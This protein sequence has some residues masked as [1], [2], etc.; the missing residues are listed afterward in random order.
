MKCPKC[1]SDNPEDT[2]FCGNCAS[3]LYPS[4]NV[5]IS[6]TK[7][8]QT[9]VKDFIKGTTF[10]GRYQLR[11]EL[12]RGGMGVVYKAEDAKLKRTVALKFLPPELT[13]IPDVKERFMREAQAA[14]ALDH[15]NIC[16]V[17]EFDEAEEKTFISMAYVE[18]QSLKTKV[19][20]GPLELD[21]ALRI[22]TQVAEGLQEAHKEGVVHRDIKSA[23]IMMDK[24]G[25]AKIMDFGL[26]K[27]RGSVQITK[28]A[29]TMGTAAYMS[30]EQVR[31][32]EVD[33]RTDIWS[34]GV[35]LYEM[36]T[37]QMPFKGDNE[38]A[39]A[40]SI[41]NEDVEPLKKWRPAVSEEL[42]RIVLR[43]L[44][45]DSRKR[46]QSVD[47][48][49]QHL[50]KLNDRDESAGTKI[51]GAR[52]FL[53]LLKRPQIA[54][55][56]LAIFLLLTTAVFIPYQKRVQLQH[57]RE[58]IPMIEKLAEERKYFEAFDMAVQAEK[59]IKNDST[60]VG[61]MPIISN[62]LTIITQPEGAEV[63]LKR[64]DPDE[65][66][67]F[68]PQEFV[69]VTPIQ[70]LRLARGDY[71]VSIEKEGF[72][73]FERIAS[74]ELIRVDS[75]ADPKPIIRIEVTLISS[76]EL[77]ADMAAVPGG[78]YL[79]VGL[80]APTTTEVQLDAFFIDKYE[81]SNAQFKEFILAGGYSDKSYWQHPFVKDG[82]MISW[83][84]AMQTF[85][86]RTGLTGPRDWVN[87]EFPEGRENHPVTGVCWYEAAA[88]A[89][90]VDKK[91]PTI[92]QW[93]KAA[94]DGAYT[95]REDIVMPWGLVRTRQTSEYQA[96][97]NGPNPTPVDSYEF[98]ISPYGCYNMAG[99]VKEWCLNEITGG[100]VAPGGSWEDPMYLFA[101]FGAFD[102]FFS[103]GSL[104]FRCVRNSPP[105]AGD[106]G[107]FRINLEDRTPPYVPVD[108]QTFKSYLSHYR[109]DKRPIDAEVIEVEE[110]AAWTREKVIFPGPKG[111]NIIAYLYLPRRFASPLQCM[112]FVPGG[113]VE[114]HDR[115]S[116]GFRSHPT[117]HR[118]GAVPR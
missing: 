52:T 110:D 19:E 39:V 14:A 24:R 41:L 62:D 31:G 38:Q 68:P 101:Q 70:G 87:Q 79:L 11:E 26:A 47:E 58:L 71:R 2:H 4:D 106:Q 89:E 22:A 56:V 80:G 73:T 112:V 69:G 49:L 113:G 7:T 86:D 16:T 102:G 108:D 64:F 25:Q 75:P 78:P 53:Q 30:P 45:K 67:Q 42:Q 44:E 83:N 84:E 21:E 90:F 77:P 103:S 114:G 96:N 48:V 66:G 18:G 34:F 9:P 76:G 54:L 61:L 37:G 29:T 12:G 116:V 105:T 111:E 36:I 117:C 27:V 81:V 6:H 82:Q 107:A 65:Q 100:Y 5:S 72:A 15:P 35:V 95:H 98:G 92:F 3:P 99:N 20:S 63:Y 33:H 74:S 55:P 40:Y 94:R 97:F 17:H 13:H 85:T 8:V 118:F 10:A 104:G 88:F 91:L 23:N 115:T 51:V 57:A 109:Y 43:T 32:K 60:L 50:K 46:Y 28:E 1:H 59:V 93:E